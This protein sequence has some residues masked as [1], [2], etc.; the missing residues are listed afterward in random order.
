MK[1]FFKLLAVLLGLLV[2]ILL[3][4]GIYLRF[5]FDPNAFKPQ[6]TAL[7]EERTGRQLSI[8]GEIGVS[9]FPWLALQAGPLV[10]GNAAGFGP[11][12]FARVGRVDARIRL[13]PLLERR[14]RP[15]LLHQVAYA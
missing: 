7:V 12:P 11:E 4:A 2:A 15:P 14:L 8:E 13:M 6:I 1:W 10:L 5:F 3:A 9:L